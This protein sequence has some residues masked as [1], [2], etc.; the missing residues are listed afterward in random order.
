MASASMSTDFDYGA[1]VSNDN[2][3]TAV[4]QFMTEVR[5]IR[6]A[7][8][9]TAGSLSEVNQKLP[10]AIATISNGANDLDKRFGVVKDSV[11]MLK[12]LLLGERIAP[13]EQAS[14]SFETRVGH[15]EGFTQRV[16]DI[17]SA[18]NDAVKAEFMNS[19]SVIARDQSKV[20]I[21]N[22]NNQQWS[23]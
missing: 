3:V 5:S 2:I 11:D 13:V 4:V 21:S 7:V 12:L 20:V 22:C 9:A 17:Q 8:E 16:E 19:S 23:K 6:N 10:S 1:V 15:L 14:L 18:V